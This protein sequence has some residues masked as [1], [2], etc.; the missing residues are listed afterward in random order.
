VSGIRRFNA[1]ESAIIY[2]SAIIS[3][4]TIPFVGFL[5][6]TVL[7]RKYNFIFI[8]SLAVYGFLI[9]YLNKRYFEKEQRLKGIYSKFKNQSILQRRIGYVVVVLTF[10]ISIILF[11]GFLSI[12]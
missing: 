8:I 7:S 3:F 5:L 2:L 12:F 4:L 11:F 6:S 10:F 1:R 9:F